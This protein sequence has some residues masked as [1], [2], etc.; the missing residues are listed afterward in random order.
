[1]YQTRGRKIKIN[2]VVDAVLWILSFSLLLSLIFWYYP[3][4]QMEKNTTTRFSNALYCACSRVLWSYGV[5]WIIFACQN[6][7]GGI[8]RWFLQL[9]QWQPL[10]RMGLSIYL[11]HRWYQIITMYDQKQPIQWDFFNQIQKFWSDVLVSIFLGAILYLSVEN[12]SMLIER[13]LHNKIKGNKK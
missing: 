2:K 3:F 6:G 1:M 5:A 8:V 13:Y 10:G 9:P 4:Q 12:P 11:V 7:S